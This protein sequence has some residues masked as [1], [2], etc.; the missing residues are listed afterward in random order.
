MRGSKG[1]EPARQGDDV[2]GV[3]EVAMESLL[4]V[5]QVCIPIIVN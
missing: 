4:K 1:K 3:E 5:P 2:T